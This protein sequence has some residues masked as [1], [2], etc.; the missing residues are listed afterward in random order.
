MKRT[1]GV[2]LPFLLLAACTWRFQRVEGEPPSVS[3]SLWQRADCLSNELAA[4]DY[5]SCRQAFTPYLPC[6]GT[7]ELCARGL[8]GVS[9]L[10]ASATVAFSF[11]HLGDADVRERALVYWPKPYNALSFDNRWRR[12]SDAAVAGIVAAANELPQQPRF[13]LHT[14]NAVGTGLFSELMRF[15]AAMDVAQVPWFNAV[16]P[17]DAAFMGDKPLESVSQL[18]VVAP[19]VPIGDAY[20]F[21]KY[22]SV[23]A[24]LSDPSMPF[25]AGRPRNHVPTAQPH[26]FPP[27][28]DFHGFDLACSPTAWCPQMHG[29]YAFDITDPSAPGPHFRALVLNTSEA[30]EDDASWGSSR[31]HLLR[32]QLEWLRTEL[33]V[34]DDARRFLVFGHHAL[35]EVEG[36]AGAQLRAALTKDPRVLAYLHGGEQHSFATLKRP[37][38]GALPLLGAGSLQ[39]F[40]QTARLV[41]VLR[42]GEA[43]YLRLRAFSQHNETTLHEPDVDAAYPQEAGCAVESDGTSFCYR[44][45]RTAGDSRAAARALFDGNLEQLQ[46]SSNGVL[47]VY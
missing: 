11:V 31:G 40:P 33:A 6:T 24:A 29:Y 3:S 4:A 45:T 19:Y 30:L 43:L 8:D 17:R 35:E 16:G 10:P 14:G 12:H 1:P 42:D 15:I 9:T 28:S 37:A 36:D 34:V 18:N 47:R 22:H 2:L 5:P 44:L 13:L 20:R 27:S 46:R 38:G 7:P 25:V 26:A 39:R 21:M 23:R 41:E 32:A